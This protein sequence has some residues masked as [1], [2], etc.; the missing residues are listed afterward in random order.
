MHCTV[1]HRPSAGKLI[2]EGFT[3]FFF[4][5]S[6]FISLPHFTI[7]SCTRLLCPTFHSCV[8]TKTSGPKIWRLEAS[9]SSKTPR[10]IEENN[11]GR[12]GKHVRLDVRRFWEGEERS[13]TAGRTVSPWNMEPKGTSKRVVEGQFVRSIREWHEFSLAR[14]TQVTQQTPGDM[15][16]RTNT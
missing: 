1:Q 15:A 6:V 14:H 8:Q 2:S 5:C 12:V 16:P 4:C 3:S 9:K 11:N 7:M 13:A 10:I